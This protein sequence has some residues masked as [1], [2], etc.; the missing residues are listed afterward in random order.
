VRAVGGDEFVVVLPQTDLAGA[1]LMAQKLLNAVEATPIVT[2]AGIVRMT[3]SI[4]AS[5]LSA[6]HDRDSATAELLIELADQCL[7]ISKKTGRGRA[8]IPQMIDAHLRMPMM[9]GLAVVR[10]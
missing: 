8:T 4:G 5:G 9:N 1:S 7:S 6:V 3:A 2:G 10:A